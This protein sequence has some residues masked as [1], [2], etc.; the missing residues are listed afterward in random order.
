MSRTHVVFAEDSLPL[1]W[2]HGPVGGTA[3]VN[4]LPSVT[5]VALTLLAL[6]P[7]ARA[8]GTLVLPAP[9]VEKT[10]VVDRTLRVDRD[11]RVPPEVSLRVERGGRIW[12]GPGV[13][14][15]VDGGLEA[16]PYPVFTGPGKVAGTPR[17]AAVLPEWLADLGRATPQGN[18]DDWAP[19]INRAIELAREGC[20]CVRLQTRRYT[21]KSPVDLT[22][23][24]TRVLADM[25]LEGSLRSTEYERGTL[26]VGETGPG[27]CV[28]DTSDS[29]GI[30][31][32]D[33]GIVRGK[34]NPSTIGLLQARGTG[35]GWAGDQFHEN[36]YID[37]GSD[38][39]ANGGF[40][41]IGVIDVAGEETRWQNLQVWANLPL[42]LT[43]SGG[44]MCTQ[45]D[46]NSQRSF[47]V[48]TRPG[49]VRPVENGS[50]TVLSLTC[51]GRL[52]AYD[53]ISPIV[54]IN[55]AGTV[56]L[57][58][59]FMQRRASGQAGITPGK[60]RYAI[61]NWNCYGFRHFGSIEGAASY[62]L[63]R[64]DL[65]EAEVNVRMAGVGET[66][67]P[68]IQLCND[69]GDYSVSDCRFVIDLLDDKRPLI[70][71]LRRYGGPDI[72]FALRNNSF[73]CN[74]PAAI[75]GR[76]L[77]VLRPLMSGNEIFFRDGRVGPNE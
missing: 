15:T 69:G 30:H 7:S 39:S 46:L 9:G 61:E 75:G 26:L 13:T 63:C 53:D 74:L 48:P 72:P 4:R 20:R 16:G 27:N 55:C 40:G 56:D 49:G 1:D 33:L 38:P 25:R 11:L 52:I 31:L 73:H 51:L 18:P 50:N 23:R 6:A 41:T 77:E 65:T 32:K 57:G 54:L 8:A 42:A 28:V 22:S 29:D 43:W 58:D 70:T 64:R 44:M 47:T 66:E 45:P 3:I 67:L 76:G 10:I 24:P 71:V 59:V 68:V 19:A 60:Y 37:L 17:V 14:I 62:M 2:V 35:T 12:I 36:L 34:R 5:W 21:V